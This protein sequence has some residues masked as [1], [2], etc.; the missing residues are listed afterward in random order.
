MDAGELDRR[1]TVQRN[2][3]VAADSRN[4]SVFGWAGL[5]TV[6]AGRRDVSDQ[7]RQRADQPDA[8]ASA[9]FRTWWI[10]ELADVGAGD[11][12][13]EHVSDT[14]DVTYAV[15]ARRELGYRDGLEISVLGPINAPTAEEEA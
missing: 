7:E 13:V 12:L 15:V 3:P 2:R 11:Q 10:P 1:V 9:R 14:E 6:S 5:A 8:A 4:E